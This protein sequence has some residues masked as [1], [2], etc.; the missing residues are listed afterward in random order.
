MAKAIDKSQVL[1]S[2]IRLVNNKLQFEGLVEGNDPISI[3]YYPPL[4]D[5]LGY[6]SL[7]LFLMSL[8]SCMGTTLLTIL[9]KL[10]KEITFF[11]ILAEGERRKIILQDLKILPS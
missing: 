8:T 4:G 5:N 7:E 6:N 1:K 9:R 2:A 10:K 11:E 3:D